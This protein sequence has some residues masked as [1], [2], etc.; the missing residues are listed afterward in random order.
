VVAEV[1]YDSK[2]FE[3]YKTHLVASGKI[4]STFAIDSKESLRMAF[5]YEKEKPEEKPAKKESK[6]DTDKMAIDFSARFQKKMDVE[7]EAS[8]ALLLKKISPIMS[9]AQEQL[10]KGKNLSDLKEML[11]N[12]YASDDLS[13]ISEYLGILA[14]NQGLHACQIDSMITEG[15]ISPMIGRELKHIALN[16]PIIKSEF[17]V[18]EKDRS[19]GIKRYFYTPPTKTDPDHINP[20][21]KASF[22]AL[23]KGM[24]IEAIKDKLLVK[25]SAE[26]TDKVL[27][28]ALMAFNA[29]SAGAKANPVIKPKKELVAEIKPKATLPDPSTIVKQQQEMLDFYKGSNNEI[30]LNSEVEF[31]PSLD[32]KIN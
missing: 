20:F 26:E 5:M 16:H 9:F 12:K 27:A 19:V 10:S 15:K 31:N 29:V 8:D 18:K 13:S 7:K 23:K 32:I 6:I 3:K 1:K 2:L 25:L 17:E 4:P 14:S 22:E 21:A 30:E 28:E 11:R 24:A